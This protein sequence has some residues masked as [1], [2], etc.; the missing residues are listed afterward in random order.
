MKIVNQL[1]KVNFK[2]RQDDDR[3][4]KSVKQEQNPISKIQNQNV[5]IVDWQMSD[6][7][8]KEKKKSEF[9]SIN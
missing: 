4:S 8:L 2:S 1:K 6:S 5:F 9:E 7:T 3:Y